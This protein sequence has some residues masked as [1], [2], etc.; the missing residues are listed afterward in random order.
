MHL[1]ISYLPFIVIYYNNTEMIRKER[2]MKVALLGSEARQKKFAPSDIPAAELI[3]FGISPSAEELSQKAGDAEYAIVDAI[4]PFTAEHIN[5]MPKLKLIHSEGVAFGSIDIKA[6][7]EK[8]IYVCNNKGANAVSVAEHTVMLIM[9]AIKD[10][11]AANRAVMEGRQI[12]TKSS[13]IQAGI[14]ELS[15]YKIGLI[16]FGDIAK[17]LVRMLAP[18]GP[19]VYYTVARD[20]KPEELAMGVTYLKPDELLS[21]CDIISL[22]LPVTAA[23]TGMVNREF[24]AKMRDGSYLINTAR[25]ELMVNEDVI[26]ALKSGKLRGAAFDTVAPEPVLK[27]NPFLNMPEKLR[28]KVIIT[29]HI[30][31]VT[32][33][34]FRKAYRNIW[35]NIAAVEAGKEPVNWVNKW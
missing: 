4:T 11:P 22:H 9:A 13:M 10:L 15:D 1:S 3:A 23:T 27:D 28:D 30:A 12:E 29:P 14:K 32:L 18:F 25:G 8:G 21:T 31:G 17:E 20:P 16:G 33:N 6:A 24:L 2:E 26:E 34:M 19:D 35:N 7:A 5:A